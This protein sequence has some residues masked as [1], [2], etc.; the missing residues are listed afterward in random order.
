M[1]G[2][3]D[4]GTRASFARTCLGKARP[5]LAQSPSAIPPTRV[6]RTCRGRVTSASA[7]S[8]RSTEV[9]ASAS[10]PPPARGKSRHGWTRAVRACVQA[11]LDSPMPLPARGEPVVGVRRSRTR[12]RSQAI[13]T[14]SCVRAPWAGEAAPVGLRSVAHRRVGHDLAKL[15]SAAA[16]DGDLGSPL[17]RVLA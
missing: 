11:T 14:K 6:P 8:P 12:S 4:R 17:Q 13:S 7:S 10:A 16:G 9:M 15:L 2:K 3:L 5:R 1:R